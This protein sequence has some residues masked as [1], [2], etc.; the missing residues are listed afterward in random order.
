[1]RARLLL[2]LCFV[3]VFAMKWVNIE[4]P[5]GALDGYT[6]SF[7]VQIGKLEEIRNGRFTN[8]PGLGKRTGF[9]LL[10]DMSPTEN[11]IT[12]V[13]YF[14]RTGELLGFSHRKL[15]AFSLAEQRW[16]ERGTIPEP[17]ISR[18]K[19]F[20]SQSADIETV[21]YAYN[22]GIQVVVWAT[23]ALVLDYQGVILATDATAWGADARAFAC[24][25]FIYIV[26]VN[27]GALQWSRINVTSP[28]FTFTSPAAFGTAINIS[29]TSGQVFDAREDDG[30][31]KFYVAFNSSAD[32]NV[33]VR[34]FEG[35]AN[36]PTQDWDSGDLGSQADNCIA[37][38][39]RGGEAVFPVWHNTAAGVVRFRPLT[40]STGAPIVAA[41]TIATTVATRIGLCRASSSSV[42]VVI[43][44]EKSTAA[45]PPSRL[46]GY[47]RVARVTTGGTLGVEVPAGGFP[48]WD[49][50]PV[51]HPW[52]DDGRILFA[53]CFHEVE[54]GTG[55]VLDIGETSTPAVASATWVATFGRGDTSGFADSAGVSVAGRRTLPRVY[56]STGGLRIWQF[57]SL[58]KQILTKARSDDSSEFIFQRGIS[59]VSVSYS[60]SRGTQ[61][62]CAEW[63]KG[64]FIAGGRPSWYDGYQLTECGFAYYPSVNR[65]DATVANDDLASSAGGVLAAG[66]YQGQCIYQWSDISGAVDRS[67]PS[68]VMSSAPGAGSQ[69]LIWTQTT[70]LLTSR[71]AATPVQVEVYRTPQDGTDFHRS[72]AY[73][74]FPIDADPSSPSTHDIAVNAANNDAA[75]ILRELLY[76]TGDILSNDGVPPCRFVINHGDRLWIGGLENDR[77]IWFSQPYVD[78]ELPRFNGNLKLSFAEPVTGFGSM[79]D[80]LVVFTQTKIYIVTGPGCPATGGL[81]LGFDVRLVTS[82]VGATSHNLIVSMPLGLMFVSLR[83]IYLLGR[84]LSV[85]FVG[86]PL[87]RKGNANWT[88]VGAVN[89]GLSPEVVFAVDD[90]VSEVGYLLVYDYEKDYWA[91]DNLLG[92][93]RP[94][95]LAIGGNT[96]LLIGSSAGDIVSDNFTHADF[97]QFISSAYIT[98]WI[99]PAT[100][101]QGWCEIGDISFLGR[102]RGA[103]KVTIVVYYDYVEDTPVDTFVFE[104]AELSALEPYQFQIKPSRQQCQAFRIGIVDS[105]SDPEE[106]DATQGMELV[107][108]TIRAGVEDSLVQ[109]PAAQV[110]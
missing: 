28:P 81:D 38:F 22:Q 50:M 98:P 34:R 71:P 63:G 100:V 1:M 44:V 110:H 19:V 13:A 35:N 32:N 101:L 92:L 58:Y 7:H 80:K 76:T 31:T 84:D 47:T 17:T 78:G 27:A 11:Y 88:Y 8:P 72:D 104:D 68:R 9:S 74:G 30:S 42:A 3:A 87:V 66:T 105:T 103:H 56:D 90:A 15:F 69:K 55:F 64:L 102:Y 23:G 106:G 49:I 94:T 45:V 6:D 43:G 29:A 36:P 4:I 79:D 91:I 10:A 24:G 82:P 20:F 2:L 65:D 62:S 96:T 40:E 93:V 83:G 75:L 67:A 61:F 97:N 60:F 59:L 33:H 52:I 5:F 54:Q 70:S 39:G 86:A 25:N 107:S 46:M 99:K 95:S 37:V 26:R 109:L 16:I 48:V 21:A 57:P 53:G 41:A 85:R 89:K 108:M 14:S 51:S 18:K 73:T 77:E 12:K